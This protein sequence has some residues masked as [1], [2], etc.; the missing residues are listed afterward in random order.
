M[1]PET[2]FAV[3][4]TLNVPMPKNFLSCAEGVTEGCRTALTVS[5][6]RALPEAGMAVGSVLGPMA[7]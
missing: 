4:S 5:L 6:Y 3:K 2:V 1:D 7:L